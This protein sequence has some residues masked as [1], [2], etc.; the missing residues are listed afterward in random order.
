MARA[1]QLIEDSGDIEREILRESVD[2][3]SAELTKEQWD[4][5]RLEEHMANL[6]L[7]LDQAGWTS[8][9][10]LTSYED[11]GPDLSQLHRASKHIRRM[12]GMNVWV[13]RGLSLR[14][15]YI[16]DGGIHYDIPQ[17]IKR[18]RGPAPK[19]TADLET[20]KKRMRHPVNQRNFF[21]QAAREEREAALYCDSQV[22]YIGDDKDYTIRQVP[23]TRITGVFS[24][25]DYPEEV[26]AYRHSWY[27]TENGKVATDLKH[28]WIFL[29]AFVDQRGK[30]SSIQDEVGASHP[31]AKTKRMFGN[32]VNSNSGWVFGVPDALGAMAWAEQYRQF[33]ISGKRMS[34]AM[35][36]IWAV[37][38]TNTQKGAEGVGVR[39]GSVG[40]GSVAAMGVSQTL[41][42]L[43]TAGQSYDFKKGLDLLAA[44]AAGVDVSVVALSS[45]PGSA[46]ASYG[47]AKALE[48]PEQL[49]TKARRQYHIDLDREVMT[50]LG[51]PEERDIWFDP[52]KESSEMYRDIQG[53][54]LK[55]GTG[56]Y[57]AE[58]IKADLEALM[59]RWSIKPIPDGILL[60]NNEKSFARRDI[61]PNTTGPQPGSG[62]SASNGGGFAPTQGSGAAT[63]PTGG[64]DQKAD[65]IRGN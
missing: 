63:N 50:W 1:T 26:W 34:D 10:G 51:Y 12:R 58:E 18:K 33:M 13:K 35:A 61:D 43:A 28:E 57:E 11:D 24:N 9:S 27:P 49:T 30:H 44:F 29:S 8:L 16:W 60:P 4:R 3:L 32:P 48:L 17:V 20:L 59:G 25:P 36:K 45:N 15:S 47:A 55:W 56:Q 14:A 7:Y 42:P 65:D 46:G 54:M 23:I 22:F 38:A 41:S 53:I 2:A 64:Q 39:M 19:E 40:D 5:E 37:A 6:D 62:G 21:S 31:V 52:I